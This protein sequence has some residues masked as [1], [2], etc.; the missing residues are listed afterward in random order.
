MS[1]L[2]RALVLALVAAL[3]QIGVLAWA[4]TAAPWSCA[5]APRSF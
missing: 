2:S 3:L 1:A 4:F 5:T